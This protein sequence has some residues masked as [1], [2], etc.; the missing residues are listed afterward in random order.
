[1][2]FIRTDKIGGKNQILKKQHF[3]RSRSVH[4]ECSNERLNITDTA[5]IQVFKKQ[6]FS[7]NLSR[8]MMEGSNERLILTDKIEKKIQ[9]LQK[10]YIHAI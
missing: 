9:F 1:M 6:H 7:C 4:D 5:K 8:S 3:V 2:R 10:R